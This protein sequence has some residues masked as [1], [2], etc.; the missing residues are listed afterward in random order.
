MPNVAVAEPHAVEGARR[1][2]DGSVEAD[3]PQAGLAELFHVS[4]TCV[5]QTNPWLVAHLKMLGVLPPA[6][7]A[8]VGDEL[9]HWAKQGRLLTTL[10]ADALGTNLRQGRTGRAVRWLFDALSTF[11]QA[12]SGDVTIY[13]E[14]FSM[15]QVLASISNPSVADLALFLLAG[16]RATWAQ[17]PVLRRALE[18]AQV[19]E[20]AAGELRRQARAAAQPKARRRRHLPVAA[21]AFELRHGDGAVPTFDKMTDVDV[22]DDEDVAEVPGVLLTPRPSK[23]HHH[24][25]GAAHV[26]A[27]GHARE[28]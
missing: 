2:R 26:T 6:L 20:A 27:A 3:L 11:G 23:Q 14:A 9:R 22:S 24:H 7:A 4:F 10:A 25:A 5:S 19:M 15:Q 18:P 1:W 21:S 12:W 8:V 13:N 16:Q 17:L 28:E